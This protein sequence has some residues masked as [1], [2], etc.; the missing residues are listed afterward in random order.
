MQTVGPLNLV[1]G[2]TTELDC[3]SASTRYTKVVLANASPFA[4]QVDTGDGPAQWLQPY[5][6][7]A[8]AVSDGQPVDVLPN[9]TTGTG[10]GQITA[11]WYLDTDTLIGTYPAPI[12]GSVSIL[13]IP[14]VVIQAG[15]VTIAGASAGTPSPANPSFAVRDVSAF[16]YGYVNNLSAAGGTFGLIG[17]PPGGFTNTELHEA[18]ISSAVAQ[19]VHLATTPGG[20]VFETL[21]M[22]ADASQT[23]DYHGLKIGN[24]GVNVIFD[25]G[26]GSCTFN[27]TWTG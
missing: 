12:T 17:A 13:N 18:L 2:Q 26:N 14:N 10:A 19:A 9:F 20:L 7:D 21:Y 22:A 23:F 4:C 16:S 8:Y 5:S 24:E 11:T 15:T 27:Y 1:L 3:P 25:I 6:A